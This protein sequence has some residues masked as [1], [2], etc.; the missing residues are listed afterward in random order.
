[1]STV[2][3]GVPTKTIKPSQFAAVT[4]IATKFAVF[5]AASKMSSNHSQDVQHH[6]LDAKYRKPF[7]NCHQEFFPRL[8]FER[9]IGD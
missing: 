1:M 9:T 2:F 4:S 3:M 8:I 6:T 5:L 7:P